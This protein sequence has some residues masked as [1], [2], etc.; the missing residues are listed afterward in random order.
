M[1]DKMLNDKKKRLIII[2]SVLVVFI[3]VTLAYVVGQI[4]DG[5]IGNANVTADT[6]DNLQF[7]VDKDIS[8]NPTQF[9]V[10]E[11]GNNLS[12]TAIGKAT[13]LANSTNKT[14][15][16]DY[17]VYFNI[18]S[19]DYTYTTEDY[20]PEIVLTITDPEGN[21]VTKL[22]NNNLEYVEAENA[23]GTITKGFDITTASGLINI[24]S[25]YEITSNSSTDATVQDGTF[26]V[27]FIN[28][29]TNQTENGGSTLDTEIILS[30]DVIN[31]HEIC[32][33]G[34]MACDITRLYNKEN[35]ET[36]GLYYHNGKVVSNICVFDGNE[37]MSYPNE[38]IS[39]D[40]ED[41]NY[42]YK[43]NYG[44][45]DSNGKAVYDG[46][47]DL[48]F[49]REGLADG[50]VA[51][52]LWNDTTNLCET[53]GGANV[54]MD[55]KSTPVSEDLCTG[56]AELID[57][58][59]SIIIYEVGTGTIKPY[60]YCM[61]NGAQVS[62]IASYTYLGIRPLISSDRC[63][64]VYS[65]AGSV[66]YYDETY[67]TDGA[68]LGYNALDV[69]WDDNE[70]VCK[71]INGDI[72]VVDN[73][74]AVTKDNCHGK[75]MSSGYS[76]Y[77][78]FSEI[79]EGEMMSSYYDAN[80][81][82]Y[83]YVNDGSDI[84]N[85]VC[86]GAGANAGGECPLHNLYRIIGIFDGKVKLI[87]ADYTTEEMLGVNSRDY[88][89][90]FTD[91]LSKYRGEIED[92]ST[93]VSYSWN[94]D[95]SERADGSNDWTTSEL[96]TINLNVNFVNYIDR[97]GKGWSDLISV[98]NWNLG[99]VGYYGTSAKSFLHYE[100]N[101]DKIYSSKIGLMY[102]S[103]YGYAY[104]P[105]HWLYSIPTYDVIKEDNWLYLGL[106]EWT[107]T[108]QTSS[109]AG[110]FYLSDYGHPFDESPNSAFAIRP[111]FYLNSDVELA[112]GDGT[113]ESPYR[114]EI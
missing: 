24:A 65:W 81:Y 97:D 78:L 105:S 59:Y 72:V 45:Y 114:I 46:Y 22:A 38:L 54:Y 98:T 88:A 53:K 92:T 10:I 58:N 85:Y 52:I 74:T 47:F 48:S 103:D 93:I 3:G 43:I 5:A 14:A 91:D 62:T 31:Y 73:S 34:T 13:L 39:S 57:D 17:Y 112:G 2:V 76:D 12:D 64:H 63:Q 94:S 99:E 50:T 20:K 7:S 18:K 49:I 96:N 77:Y 102:P 108:P 30:S 29:T 60:E 61:Y 32:E 82:S 41:C 83:R 101:S 1:E 107:I 51:E 80:D 44:Y 70:G 11:G 71:T 35:P 37:V 69:A 9:N 56:Y 25:L 104:R 110:A 40:S 95:Q 89:G 87:K 42:V 67:I 19:N 106:A 68:F 66:I 33:P 4:S 79:G 109:Y 28:L 26:T 27:T 21:L 8:L 23:D 111:V 84:N 15:T 75:A 100:K 86:F 16:Y 55:V 36:N 113:Q 6:T 90:E